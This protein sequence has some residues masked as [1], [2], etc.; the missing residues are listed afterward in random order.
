[1]TICFSPD[2]VQLMRDALE[3]AELEVTPTN[4]ATL[5]DALQAAFQQQLEYEANYL[6]TDM[7]DEA[8]A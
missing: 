8:A 1:M 6:A 3:G 2:D 4:L 7:A 5:A